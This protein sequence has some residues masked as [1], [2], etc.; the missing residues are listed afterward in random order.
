ML[1]GKLLVNVVVIAEETKRLLHPDL[2]GTVRIA[3]HIAVLVVAAVLAGPPHWSALMSE[4]PQHI[5]EELRDR[6]TLEGGVGGIAVETYRHADADAPHGD[7][8]GEGDGPEDGALEGGRKDQQGRE[9]ARDGDGSKRVLHPMDEFGHEDLQNEQGREHVDRSGTV[10]VRPGFGEEAERLGLGER[11]PGRG[12]EEDGDGQHVDA[13]SGLVHVH[14]APA[15]PRPILRGGGGPPGVGGGLIRRSGVGVGVGMT[16]AGFIN[17][18]SG[19]RIGCED[20]SLFQLAA[21]DHN[22]SEPPP[23]WLVSSGCR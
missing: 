14:P 5:E 21:F 15:V 10:V 12:G 16:C 3:G 17:A 8:D 20:L 6:A 22:T 9:V 18:T 11:R 2:D 13:H 23:D 4:T 19:D 7:G 1:R